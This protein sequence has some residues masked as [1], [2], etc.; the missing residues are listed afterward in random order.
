MPRAR[1][2][3]DDLDRAHLGGVTLWAAVL[4]LAATLVTAFVQG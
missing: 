3:G 2:G 4:L 1:G